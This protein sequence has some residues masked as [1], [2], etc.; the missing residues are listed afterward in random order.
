[1]RAEANR[2]DASIETRNEFV[3]KCVAETLRKH[4]A[5]Q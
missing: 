2:R 3:S 5:S 4:Q 1:M